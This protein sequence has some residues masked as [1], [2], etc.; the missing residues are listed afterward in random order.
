M[1]AK[2]WTPDSWRHKPAQQI[3]SYPDAAKLAEV[4]ARLS[5][6]PPLIFAG[7]ARRLQ[8]RLAR[9]AAGEAFL[10][11]GRSNAVGT[12]QRKDCA[13]LILQEHLERA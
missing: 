8:E 10:L 9:V 5:T 6:Y 2:T 1:K 4:E 3:P 7:E 13:E 11:Q 12:R